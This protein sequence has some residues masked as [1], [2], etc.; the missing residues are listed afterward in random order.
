VNAEL[1]LL[2]DDR[3]C[4][5]CRNHC[6]YEAIRYVFSEKDY[7]LTVVIDAARCPGCGACQ[8]VCPASPEK[9]IVVGR[10]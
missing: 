7:M 9:A 6:P 8:V 5:A 1:C 3:E 4:S 10:R 2:S